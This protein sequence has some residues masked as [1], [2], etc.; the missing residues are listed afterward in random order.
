MLECSVD[1]CTRALH[2]V[3]HSEK[4]I[5]TFLW[6]NRTSSSAYNKLTYTQAQTPY[7]HSNNFDSLFP[8][9]ECDDE[10]EKIEITKNKNGNFAH[11][12]K[13]STTTVTKYVEIHF[14]CNKQ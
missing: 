9:N 6:K 2:K 12:M 5:Y 4:V 7:T 11:K 1:V 8:S 3:I 10:S 14:I 13:A